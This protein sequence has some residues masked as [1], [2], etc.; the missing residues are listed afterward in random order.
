MLKTD[1]NWKLSW[2]WWYLHI[3][4]DLKWS[5][6][7]SCSAPPLPTYLGIMAPKWSESFIIS[8]FSYYLHTL[9]LCHF[10][11]FFFF[12]PPCSGT[13]YLQ[14]HAGEECILFLIAIAS[15]SE[16][17]HLCKRFCC[18]LSSCVPVCLSFHRIRSFLQSSFSPCMVIIS[19][20]ILLDSLINEEALTKSAASFERH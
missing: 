13:F 14:I 12:F 17:Q 18:L 6:S 15:H 20:G 10:I 19:V 8:T 4:N 11:G 9:F 1:S 5:K 7:Y 16:E 3:I 2:S